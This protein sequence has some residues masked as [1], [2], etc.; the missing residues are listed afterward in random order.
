[1]GNNWLILLQTYYI[2][3]IFRPEWQQKKSFLVL[4]ANHTVE[5]GSWNNNLLDHF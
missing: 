5:N 3:N 2:N 4:Y 1:M